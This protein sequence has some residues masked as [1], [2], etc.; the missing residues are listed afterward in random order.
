LESSLVFPY[1]LRVSLCIV[2]KVR[3]AL[4][5]HFRSGELDYNNRAIPACQAIF[6]SFFRKI[7]LL[8]GF[9]VL[10]FHWPFSL[11]SRTL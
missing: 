10:I 11:V 5:P 8:A 2:F 1:C 3:F 9:S 4:F 7:Y 6:F